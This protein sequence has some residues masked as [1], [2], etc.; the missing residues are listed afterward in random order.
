MSLDKRRALTAIEQALTEL[1]YG[2][3][4]IIV[5]DGRVVQIDRTEKLRLEGHAQAQV[6][7]PVHAS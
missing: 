7:H 3:I 2:S 1:R 5:H 6:K 4:E